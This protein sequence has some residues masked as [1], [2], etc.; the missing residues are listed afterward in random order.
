MPINK[1]AKKLKEKGYKTLYELCKECGRKTSIKHDNL[2]AHLKPLGIKIKTI[3]YYSAEEQIKIKEWINTPLLKK[4]EATLLKKYNTSSFSKLSSFKEKLSLS[5][6]S[7][8]EEFIR[9]AR[10]KHKEGYD[11]SEVIYG[12]NAYEKVKIICPKGHAFFMTP[13]NFLRGQ[14]CPECS[15][16]KNISIGE[17]KIKSF[18]NKKNI[19]FIQQKRFFFIK[20]KKMLPVDFYLPNYNIVIEFQGRQHF[21]EVKFFKNNL[22]YQKYNDKI[23]KENCLKN[24]IIFVEIKYNENIENKLSEFL[25]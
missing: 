9:K 25:L 5:K 23:K 1:E 2:P 16:R 21:E 3:T 19:K 24:G 22:S 18:L 17:E 7:N 13:H 15:K 8:T 11:Y 4:R 10:K 14:N 6:R 20:N 12:A